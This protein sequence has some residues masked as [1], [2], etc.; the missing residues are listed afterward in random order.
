MTGWLAATPKSWTLL[1]AWFNSSGPSEFQRNK[2]LNVVLSLYMLVDNFL[3]VCTYCFTVLEKDDEKEKKKKTLSWNFIPYRYY[4]KMWNL[5]SKKNDWWLV[6]FIDWD[7]NFWNYMDYSKLDLD[8]LVINYLVKTNL[9]VLGIRHRCWR[10]GA[11]QKPERDWP[12]PG[13]NG[14]RWNSVFYSWRPE[15]HFFFHRDW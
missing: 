15:R 7:F 13:I 10:T 5:W 8:K 6:D 1:K 2:H 4:I 12:P 14:V 9:V 11:Q 3:K